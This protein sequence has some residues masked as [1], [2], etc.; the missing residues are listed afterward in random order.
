[1]KNKQIILI[2][3][4]VI[5]LVISFSFLTNISQQENEEEI[6]E[7]FQEI[8]LEQVTYCEQDNECMRISKDCCGCSSMG[9]DTTIN[10]KYEDY[11]KTKLDY[12]CPIHACLTAFNNHWTCY[13]Q[14]ECINN[15][16]EFVK[17]S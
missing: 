14:I 12:E 17:S 3:F 1:M 13:A 10:R 15:N 11:W 16:C 8:P 4:L 7:E 5:L 6:K 2:V 9:L